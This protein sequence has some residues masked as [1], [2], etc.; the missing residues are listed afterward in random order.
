MPIINNGDI[1]PVDVVACNRNESINAVMLVGVYKYTEEF[2]HR[3]YALVMTIDDAEMFLS[4]G[5]LTAEV[6]GVNFNKL[7]KE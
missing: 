4:Q 3:F 6:G 7:I 1:I 2:D 5:K